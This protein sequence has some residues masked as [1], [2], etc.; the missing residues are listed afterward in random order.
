MLDQ[1]ITED[2]KKAMKAGNKEALSAIRMLKSAIKDR[3]IELRRDMEDEEVLALIGKL[4][5]QRREAARQYAEAGRA[6]L[7]AKELREADVY[8]AYLPEP[9]SE[10]ELAAMLD[11]VLAE[12]GA[13]SLK[14]MGKVMAEMRNRAAGRADMGQLSALVKSRLA[15]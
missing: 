9:L 10:T 12:T 7:E 11:T 3:Q 8:I 6:D 2:M 4:V 1:R 15:A 14:D 5:K 13:A